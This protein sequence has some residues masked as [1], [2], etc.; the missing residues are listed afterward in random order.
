MPL[1]SFLLMK[2]MPLQLEDLM[3]KPELTEKCKE[4]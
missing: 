4:F 3:P 2:W 1:Q